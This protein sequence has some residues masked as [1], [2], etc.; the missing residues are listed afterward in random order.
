MCRNHQENTQTPTKTSTKTQPSVEKTKVLEKIKEAKKQRSE[1][2]KNNQWKHKGFEK[3]V[4][5]NLGHLG[6]NPNDFSLQQFNG[7]TC[8]FGEANLPVAGA[9]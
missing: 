4:K 3:K 7:K 9:A 1:T 8:A 6:L 5:E 2:N